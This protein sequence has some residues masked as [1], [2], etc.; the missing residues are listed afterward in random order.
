MVRRLKGC[1]G[2]LVQLTVTEGER[3]EDAQRLLPQIL[4]LLNILIC[5]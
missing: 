5:Y 1:A 3:A 2:A 4:L